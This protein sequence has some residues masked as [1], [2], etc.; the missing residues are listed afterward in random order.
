MHM[1]APLRLPL[2]PLPLFQQVPAPGRVPCDNRD[3]IYGRDVES[4]GT[5]R[6][7]DG[8][9]DCVECVGCGGPVSVEEHGSHAAECFGCAQPEE[10][11]AFGGGDFEMGGEA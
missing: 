5:C 6:T 2:S 11:E 1:N 10:V 3:C 4:D 9:G 8:E 7:C